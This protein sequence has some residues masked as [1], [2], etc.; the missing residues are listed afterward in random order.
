MSAGSGRRLRW[1]AA[2]NGE[3]GAELGLAGWLGSVAGIWGLR[4]EGRERPAGL[5]LGEGTGIARLDLGGGTG[6]AGLELR[7]A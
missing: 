1:E 2:G 5:E 6:L 7:G 4:W 3:V